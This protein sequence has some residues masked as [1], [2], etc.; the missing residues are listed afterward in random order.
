MDGWVDGCK[1]CIYV[2]MCECMCMTRSS[3]DSTTRTL[4]HKPWRPG[5][6]RVVGSMGFLVLPDIEAML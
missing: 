1:A 5:T 2:C 4:E 6:G 3:D